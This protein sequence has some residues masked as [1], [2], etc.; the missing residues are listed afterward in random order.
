MDHAIETDAEALWADTL[1]LLEEQEIS[2]PLA[3]MLRSCKPVSLDDGTLRISTSMRLV[4]KTVLKN[5]AAIEDC[6]A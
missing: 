6:L 4:Q 2:E 1:D 5:S 3:A